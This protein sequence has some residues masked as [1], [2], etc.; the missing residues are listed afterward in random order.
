M[1][2]R[3][4]PMC[5]KFDP[6]HTMLQAAERHLLDM[7]FKKFYV[8]EALKLCDSADMVAVLQILGSWAAIDQ[9]VTGRPDPAA[10]LH[11]SCLS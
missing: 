4:D 6:A 1:D 8:Q 10:A 2:F 3:V 9:G 5:L 11:G 7:G